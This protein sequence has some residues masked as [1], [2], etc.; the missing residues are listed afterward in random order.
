MSD[1]IV[2]NNNYLG[3][4][5]VSDDIVKNNVLTR[6]SNTSTGKNLPFT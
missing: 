2:K 3:V 5:E 6:H 4:L 1:D